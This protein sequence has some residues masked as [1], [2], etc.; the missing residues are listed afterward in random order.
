MGD[1]TRSRAAGFR[2]GALVALLAF[3]APAR[4][5]CVH[6]ALSRD[7]QPS[8]AAHFT[9]LIRLGAM[10]TPAE[11]AMTGPSPAPTTADPAPIPDPTR[12]CAGPTCAGGRG[13]PPVRSPSAEPGSES[14]AWP[15]LTTGADAP[16]AA[17]LGPPEGRA[18]PVRRGASIFHPPRPVAA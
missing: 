10:G 8:G 13:L 16:G 6:D 1:P 14:W 5:G 12:P 3:G 18:R 11:E 2:A 15:G 4:A 17:R 9:W 7:R